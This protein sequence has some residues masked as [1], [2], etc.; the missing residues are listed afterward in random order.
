ML[1]DPLSS[2]YVYRSSSTAIDVFSSRDELGHSSK[3]G[4]HDRRHFLLPIALLSTA[5]VVAISPLPAIASSVK[6]RSEGYAVQRSEREWAYVLSGPQYNILRVGGTE[7]QRSSI[8]ENEK[9]AGTFVCAGCRTPLFTSTAKFRSGTGWP[10]FASALVGVEQEDVNPIQANLSGAEVRCKS[11]GGHL[12]DVFNDGWRFTGTPA[13]Q[14]GK[15]YCINGAAMVF[16]A[17]SG[18]KEVYGDQPPPNKV[19]EYEP[20]MYRTSKAS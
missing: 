6:S 15:R 11:C 4:H 12:G 5:S 13:F 19:I 3:A 17:E 2:S 18:E 7:R 1:T 9:R 10:S 14:T 8:L 20:T 16:Q